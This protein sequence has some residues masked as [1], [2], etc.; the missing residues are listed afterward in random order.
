MGRRWTDGRT[1]VWSLGVVLYEMLSGR[2]PFTGER[3]TAVLY[4]VVHEEPKALK[5][6][7]P[8]ELCAIV[9]RALEKDAR[10]RYSSAAEM[11]A[12]LRRYR[13][14]RQAAGLTILRPKV[15]I[16]AIALLLLLCAA[17]AWWFHRQSKVRWAREQALPEIERL[18]LE[19]VGGNLD[20]AGAYRVAEGAEKYIGGDPRLAE[21]LERCSVRIDLKTEPAGAAIWFRHV[22]SPDTEWR[23]LGESPLE[24]IRLPAGGFL[25]KIEKQG[26]ETVMAMAPTFRYDANSKHRLAPRNF[27]RVLDPVGKLPPGMVRVAGGGTGKL[28]DFFIDK[29]EVTNRQ[30]KEFIDAGGYRDRKH[31]KHEFLKEGKK[32]A[33]EAAMA[34][35]VDQ[36]GRPGPSTWSAGEPPAGQDAY[37]VSGVSWYEAAAYAEF[38]GKGL[39]GVYHWGQAAGVGMVPVGWLA[40][41]SNV[42]TDGPAVVGSRPGMTAF[43]AYD[44]AGNV[45]EW[46]WNEAKNGRVVR[47]GAWNDAAYMFSYISQAAPFDRSPRNGFRCA[48]YPDLDK[49]PD[50][51][52]AT[53]SGEEA[54][55]FYKQ[56]PVADSVFEV[57]REQFSYDKKPLNARTEWRNESVAGWIQE[58]VILDAA[59]GSEQLP[60]YLFL[61][62][63]SRPPY[64]TVVYFPGTHTT[65]MSSS[66]DLDQYYEFVSVL[67]FVVKN[68]RAVV[69]PVYKGTFE[70]R[71]GIPAEGREGTDSRHFMELIVRMVQ[72]FRTCL[73]YLESRTDFDAKR[74]AY[75]GYS[76][77]GTLGAIIP[78]VENRLQ[79]SVLVLGGMPLSPARPEIRHINYVTRVKVPTLMLNGRYD[80]TFP[81]ET[82]VKPMFDLLGTPAAHKKL[83]AYDTDHFIPRNELIKETLAWLDRYLGP[84]K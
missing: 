5:E 30:Y 34:E 16:S 32:L 71:E 24:K 56:R 26:Y 84:V 66:K 36:S 39:P 81:F 73:D 65:Y 60:V 82:S 25:W 59:Y 70:R 55:D 29:Y 10:A 52:F 3:Q 62:R 54:P 40:R 31:W 8:A 47:G 79:A 43:G 38:R 9:K 57:Y 49:V 22:S 41:A 11:A 46:C 27:Q 50:K 33:W 17:G 74:L 1:D 7:A 6:T 45:R 13:E 2:L 72:D 44:M 58:K 21:L 75:L 35:L 67:S 61:P 68:G 80:T 76:W 83:V 20:A 15:V 78:A 42:G 69:F 63:N 77:G 4:A 37:P 53:W 48:L 64:Q 51:M 28:P 14:G 19:S 18:L 23:Y 12:D